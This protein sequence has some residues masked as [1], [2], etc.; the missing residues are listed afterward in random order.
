MKAMNAIGSILAILA[1]LTLGAGA[2]RNA[3]T[4][5][6]TRAPA[7]ECVSPGAFPGGFRVEHAIWQ[8]PSWVAPGHVPRNSKIWI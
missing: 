3:T 7:V 5:G 1:V 6:L 4:D 2:T 8:R